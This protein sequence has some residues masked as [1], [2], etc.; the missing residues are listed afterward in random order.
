MNAQYDDI[1]E[2]YQRSKESPL[3]LHIEAYTFME[4]AGDVC[5]Q[6]IL[7]LACGEGFYTRRLKAAGASSVL[8][9]DISA[10]MIA[11]AEAQERDE[12]LSIEYLC[13]DVAELDLVNLDGAADLG[14]VDLVTAAYLLHY[15]PDEQTLTRMCAN[16]AAQLPS[17]GRFVTLN[18]NPEQTAEQLAG[19]EQYGFN[20]M[21]ELPLRDGAKIT[22]W[23]I[24]GRDMFQIHAYW[25]S[26]A[27]YERA[28]AAAGFKSVEWRPLSLDEAG[29]AAHGEDYWHEYLSNP[30]IVALECRV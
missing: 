5:D 29:I 20:K 26:R 17:G 16:I 8:G 22:Y 28:L 7:D 24:A 30:P 11:L 25:F 9:V 15:A 14:S 6:R 4:L 13:A 23:M 12:P 18:E 3:R 27:T 21:A 1:A 19:Y 2:Q 10:E